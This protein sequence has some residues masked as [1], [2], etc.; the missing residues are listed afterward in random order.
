[1]RIRL[2]DAVDRLTEVHH[3]GLGAVFESRQRGPCRVI[4]NVLKE[5]ACGM[6]VLVD[7]SPRWV[8]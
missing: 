5:G 4:S 3:P 1:M 8:W 6:C 2:V 7:R